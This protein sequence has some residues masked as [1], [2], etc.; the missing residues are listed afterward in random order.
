MGRYL[1][2]RASNRV[3]LLFIRFS[4][5]EGE[6]PVRVITNVQVGRLGTALLIIPDY[7]CRLF[8]R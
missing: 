8:G 6:E 7:G 2:T 3:L 5:L 1:K 4:D